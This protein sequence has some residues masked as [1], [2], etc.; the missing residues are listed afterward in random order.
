MRFPAILPCVRKAGLIIFLVAIVWTAALWADEKIEM[1]TYVPAVMN[2]ELER[3]HAKKATVGT[4]YSLTG[5]NP[6]DAVL[7]DGHLLVS[8]MIGIGTFTASPPR[9]MQFRIRGPNDA[10]TRVAIT[11][12]VSTAIPHNDTALRVGIG[13][14]NPQ[15]LLD[16]YESEDAAYFRIW[17]LGDG[18][19]FSG[20]ELQSEQGA[21]GELGDR[22]WQI[23]HKAGGAG[24]LNDF[25][26]NYRDDLGSW[27]VP[28]L[29]ITPAGNVGIGTANPTG[30]TT[31]GT[32]VLAIADGTAPVGGR[33]GQALLYADAELAVTE[34]FALD[35]AGNATKLSPHNP[36]T[37]EWEFYSKN[38]RTGR[39][40]RIRME[41][42]VR[43]IE[44]LTG[45][46][47]IEEWT[48]N[49]NE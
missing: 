21:S 26:I 36:E 47:F 13:T 15:H 6:T 11:R 7:E 4:P 24:A 32:R 30:N 41:E 46:K 29:A 9:L 39:V 20:V 14:E 16:I 43:E 12:G 19:N 2:G 49:P 10:F 34:L 44:R 28:R 18:E 42:L 5:P 40:V 38:S 3:L 45:K 33:S 17:G 23:A 37:G 31:A 25:Q 27:G 35:G 48:E 8:K 1:S 22:K